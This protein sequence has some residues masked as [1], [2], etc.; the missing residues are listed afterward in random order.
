M[1]DSRRRSLLT[2]ALVASLL[3]DNAPE[4]RMLC[5]WLDN[6]TGI[7]HVTVG[8]DRQGFDLQLTKYASRGWRAN[9]YTSGIEHAPISSTGSAW[10]AT[11]W[12]AV[13]RAA[14]DALQKAY[15]EDPPRG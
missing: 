7:G 1:T 4:R 5:A 11:P 3:P 14:L 10:E 12:R 13:Q 6:W 8:M 9:F 15:R 2:T